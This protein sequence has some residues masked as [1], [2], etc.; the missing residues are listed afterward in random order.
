MRHPQTRFCMSLSTCLSVSKRKRYRFHPFSYPDP[1]LIKYTRGNALPILFLFPTSVLF[2][3]SCHWLHLTEFSSH[4]PPTSYHT[5]NLIPPLPAT[6]QFLLA[7][8]IGLLKSNNIIFQ[9]FWCSIK[10][11]P[12]SFFTINLPL[13]FF[14]NIFFP[15]S[16]PFLPRM[17][18]MAFAKNPQ[19]NIWAARHRCCLIYWVIRNAIIWKEISTKRRGKL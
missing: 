12:I 15:F 8:T 5:F 3:E 7:A 14:L 18:E 13:H 9:G 10:V 16:S 2:L 4:P 11:S 1:F 19:Q 17:E 6:V